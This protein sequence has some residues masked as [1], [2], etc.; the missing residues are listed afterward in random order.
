MEALKGHRTGADQPLARCHASLFEVFS[1]RAVDGA[2]I[3][4]VL[5]QLPAT[6]APV[7]WVQDRLSAKETGRPYLA[8][9]GARRP[10]IM[11]NLSRAADVLWA[12]EDGL[13]CT[14]LGAVVGEVWGAPKALDFTASKRLVLRAEAAG[15]P[16]WLI[17]RAA[18]PD[19]SA[20]RDRWR[21]ASLPAG[22]HPHDHQAPGQPRWSAELFRSRRM[23]PGTWVASYD[24]AA[25]RLNFAAP[26]RDGALGQGDGPA[27]L[28]AAQ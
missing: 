16:C 27:R 17:R 25:H 28:R 13:R 15:V 24:R 18:S 19:L 7:L 23:Q 2:A 9:I 14:T 22:A 10:M 4:F 8:G 26:V 11:V 12:M 1:E 6:S 3:G 20:A 21:V 5:A